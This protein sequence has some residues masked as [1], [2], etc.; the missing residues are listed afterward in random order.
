MK[1]CSKLQT[2]YPHHYAFI[3]LVGI[4]F[5]LT[6]TRLWFDIQ[7]YLYID[8]RLLFIYIAILLFYTSSTQKV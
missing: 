3:M 7:T 8:F 2:G 4:V 6:T 5:L 1:K